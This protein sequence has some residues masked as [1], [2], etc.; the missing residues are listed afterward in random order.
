MNSK[1]QKCH[2]EKRLTIFCSI[3]LGFYMFQVVT[4]AEAKN[5]KWELLCRQRRGNV[6]FDLF[7]V[8]VAAVSAA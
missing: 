5:E 7:C 6:L 3:N 1:L 4:V 2:K 8:V